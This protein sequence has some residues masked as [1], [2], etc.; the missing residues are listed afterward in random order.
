[1]YIYKITMN[2]GTEYVVKYDSNKIEEVINKL[3]YENPTYPK[4]SE[5]DLFNKDLDGLDKILIMS[6]FVSS[7]KYSQD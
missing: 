6:N 7:V 5:W 2:N 4:I 3:F 1:M